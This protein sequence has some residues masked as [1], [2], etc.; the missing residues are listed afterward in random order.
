M[1]GERLLRRVAGCLLPLAA[2]AWLAALA[3]AVFAADAPAG[4]AECHVSGIRNTVLCGSLQRPLDPAAPAGPRITLRYMVV[5][6]MARRK[7]AD[8]VFMLAGGPG[9]SA[10]GV[11]AATLPIFARLNNRRDIVFVDQRG[12]G[13]S[14]PLD[15][16]E[17]GLASAAEQADADRQLRFIVAC[18]AQLL[19]LPYIHGERDLGFFS[20]WIA[21]QDLD[22]VRRALG[23][24]RVDLVG[25]SY[26]TRVALEY[27]RQFPKAV[28]RTVID[29]VAPPDMALPASFSV[30]NQRALD[31]LVAACAAEPA[32]ATAH[33]AL[34]N[35]LAALLQG[36]P[37]RVTSIQPTTGKPEEFVLTRDQVIGALAGRALC[38]G[39]GRGLAASDRRCSWRRLRRPGRHRLDAGAAQGFTAGHRHAP[40]G[41]LR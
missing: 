39:R 18:K 22:A 3:P 25:A 14:A 21:V 36:L 1:T 6:A 9:Q 31:S 20:T 17:A 24:E 28:R 32:C 5:P 26:G 34:G 19:K 13:G 15:C 2:G 7:I 40:L 12:T 27:L 41:G 8:P 16:P 4:L 37:R 11:A 29:G 23:V 35:R 10:V 33:P 38:A 30:D